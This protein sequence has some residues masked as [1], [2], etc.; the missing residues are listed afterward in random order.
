M[1]SRKLLFL[2]ACIFIFPLFI[3]CGCGEAEDAD[4]V[5]REG[6][7]DYIRLKD[8][9]V[10]DRAVAK[11]RA[12]YQQLLKA[13][14]VSNPDHTGYAIK[15]PFGT[16]SGEEEHIWINDISW[17]GVRFL[18]VINNE[19]V[20]TKE[21]SLGDHVEVPPD[22][23]SD[24]MYVDGNTLVGGFTVRALHYQQS[25]EDQKAFLEQTGLVVPPVDF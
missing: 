13:L 7:P 21:V 2:A 19:P 12:T 9:E 17:D 25:A 8:D 15:K 22:E 11:A 20:D 18:G 4:V 14:E 10:L 6:E 5:K 16:P 1:H 3:I 23:L 24:W